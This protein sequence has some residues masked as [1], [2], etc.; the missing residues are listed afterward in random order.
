MR[1]AARIKLIVGALLV[2]LLVAF[3]TRHL[4]QQ[5]ST[6][7]ELSATLKSQEYS[8][9]TDYAGVLVDQ[10]VEPGDEVQAGDSVAV[11]KSNLL[12]R[13][14]EN[15]LVDPKTSP[16]EIRDS[17]T[18]VLRATSAGTVTKAPFIKGAFL[19]A[20]TP[21]VQI[22]VRDTTYVEAGFLLT[23]QE[24]AEIRA[25]RTVTVTLPN[26][27]QVTATITEVNVRTRGDRAA[28]TVTATAKELAD[29]PLFGAGTPVDVQVRLPKDGLVTSVAAA[30]TGLLT[31]ASQR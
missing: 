15:G 21:L 7:H 18:L 20:G 10:S 12:S 14:I 13:D 25:A 23:T 5:M 29:D 27:D 9:G 17:N 1:L 26:D 4:D 3:L 2:V 19:P 30:V 22:R 24:Y 16:Y 6:V 28:T 31:P 11:I 8:L